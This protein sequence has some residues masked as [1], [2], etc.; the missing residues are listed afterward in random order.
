MN[1]ITLAEKKTQAA[2]KLNPWR[3]MRE[4]LNWDPF[5]Q[6]EPS[7]AAQELT[8]LPEFEVSENKDGYLFKADLP[9]VKE[10]D[11]QISLTGDRL[12]I[13]GKRES[14]EEHKGETYYVC[15]R[16]YGQFS[17][18]FTLPEGADTGHMK[19]DLSNGVLT[20]ALPKKPGAQTRQI[21]IGSGKAKS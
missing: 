1:P 20:I 5:R 8:F 13:S 6:M 17:R 10:P 2:R 4:L 14:A 9:G 21:Q 12:L 11:I 16:S 3:A 19:A 18:S 15:E 7:F